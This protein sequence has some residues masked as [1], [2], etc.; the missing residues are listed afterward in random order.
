MNIFNKI[1][2]SVEKSSFIKLK[3]DDFD[4]SNPFFKWVAE[5][6]FKFNGKNTKVSTAGLKNMMEIAKQ[7]AFTFITRFTTNYE[8]GENKL[9]TIFGFAGT[10]C[11]HFYK[12]KENELVFGS[13]NTDSQ[14]YTGVY[15]PIDE[16]T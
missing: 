14:F 1:K 2:K 3:A 7:Q 12:T 13:R 4:L 11:W 10:N 5:P 8:P 6:S 16:K 9:K 15:T